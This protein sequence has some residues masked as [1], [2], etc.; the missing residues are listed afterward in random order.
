MIWDLKL[1][2]RTNL[3]ASAS[4][5]GTVKLWDTS[6]TKQPLRASLTLDEGGGDQGKLGICFGSFLRMRRRGKNTLMTLMAPN[7]S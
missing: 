6:R 7:P 4:S 2:E 3:L 5:D 1:D